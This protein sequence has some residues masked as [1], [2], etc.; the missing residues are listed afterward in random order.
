[1]S[2][3]PYRSAL[4][5]GTGPGIGAAVARRLKAEGVTLALAARNT[6]KLADLAAE[7]GAGLF[8]ADATQ[9]A[10][11]AKL[12]ADVEAR[13]GVPEIVVYNVRGRIRGPLTDLVPREVAEVIAASAFGGFLAVQQ[14]A[15]RMIPQ[16]K[17]AIL[18][19]GATA[20]IKGFANSAAY[21]MGKFALRG[22]AESAARELG[23][24]GI[25]VAHIVIDGSVKS[26][27]RPEPAD[28]PDGML[29]PDA[30]AQSYIALLRQPRSAWTSEIILRPW[31]ESF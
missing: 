8:A 22:L 25:H 26:A 2:A 23:P 5:I 31:V 10:Q 15:R 3:L 4:I 19:T 20:S 29:A 11:V 21:A 18:L 17:G 16:G 30:I 28:K 7:T 27:E 1:M 6:D 24:K 13:I 14:A 9:E 12:F